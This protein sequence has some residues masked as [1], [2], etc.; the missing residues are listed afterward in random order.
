MKRIIILLVLALLVIGLSLIGCA[1][2]PTPEPQN[3]AEIGMTMAAQAMDAKATQMR[4][5]IQYTATAQVIAATQNVQNTQAAAAVTEQF[6]A[7]AQATDQQNR[8]DLAAT[9]QQNRRDAAAAE[10]RRRDDAA[11]E[12]ARRDSEA[13]AEQNQ[14]NIVGTATAQQQNIWNQATLEVLPTHAYWTQQ[15]VFIEQTLAADQAKLSNLEVEQQKDTNTI[16]WLAPLLAV[17]TIIVVF[18]IVQIRKS[19]MQKVVNEED[20]TVEGLLLDGNRLIRPQ[21]MPG[22]VLILDGETVR[23]PD[24]TDPETQREVTR[25]AQ[26]IEALRAMPTQAPTA[27]AALMTNSI[28]GETKAP[29][30]KVMPAMQLPRE[31]LDELSDQVV[32]EE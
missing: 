14:Q 10:Q 17:A 9:E 3:P 1:T 22:P 24:V 32:E 13:T 29:T 27:N 18:A 8:R 25:R 23:A 19:R 2:P 20:G 16:D 4:I 31:V 15:A 12:Q 7:D 26:A 5:D 21:L 6:R 28:F 11:T 30:V